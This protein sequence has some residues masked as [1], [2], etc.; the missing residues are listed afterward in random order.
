MVVKEGHFIPTHKVVITTSLDLYDFLR[1]YHHEITKETWDI[2]QI[3]YEGTTGVMR[4]RL[5]ILTHEYELFRIKPKENINQM[6][7]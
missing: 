5:G 7:T 1:V 6:Q 2:L 4:A 3:T